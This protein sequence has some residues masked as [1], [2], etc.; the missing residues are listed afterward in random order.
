[1]ADDDN[2]AAQLLSDAVDAD[3]KDKAPQSQA[4]ATTA[5]TASPWDDLGNYEDVKKRLEFS[6][7]WEKRAKENADAAKK[8]ADIEEANKTEAQKLQDRLAEAEKELTEH[9]VRAIRASAAKEAGLDGDMAEFLTATEPDTA[10]KQAKALAKR[11]QPAKVDLRQGA[12]QPT[13][14]KDDA[15][16][17]LRRAAGYDR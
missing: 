5:A 8:L 16:A 6:R 12:R 14:P 7:T 4:P 2:D 3:K 11:V 9:R 10:L 13:Q 17:W 1:M 15:N